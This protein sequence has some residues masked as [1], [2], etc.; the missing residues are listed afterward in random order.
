MLMSTVL[1]VR[2]RVIRGHFITFT[3]RLN[4]GSSLASILE[5]LTVK[6]TF[7]PGTF[8]SHVFQLLPLDG[9]QGARFTL[10]SVRRVWV[11]TCP[12]CCYPSIM[13]CPLLG[14]VCSVGEAGSPGNPTYVFVNGG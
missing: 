12:A 11:C 8:W 9:S 4:V 14:A 3:R 2:L 5:T 6:E 13:D 7:Q 1:Y 10:S